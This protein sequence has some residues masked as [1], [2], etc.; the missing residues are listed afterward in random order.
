MKLNE[1]GQ[2]KKIGTP[3]VLVRE[4]SAVAKGTKPDDILPINK[5]H[6]LLGKLDENSDDIGV[7]CTKIR[8]AIQEVRNHQSAPR[9]HKDQCNIM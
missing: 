7:I 2:W 4:E 3:I 6:S 5:D 1:Y 9:R 8:Q